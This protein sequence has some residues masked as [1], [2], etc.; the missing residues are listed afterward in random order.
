MKTGRFFFSC[1][2]NCKGWQSTYDSATDFR[3][4]QVPS[5]FPACTSLS[6]CCCLQG[7][8]RLPEFQPSHPSPREEEGLC[9]T[10]VISPF[11]WMF[12]RSP[13]QKLPLISY[14]PELSHM[15]NTKLNMLPEYIAISPK[16]QCFVLRKKERGVVVRQLEVFATLSV[17]INK[18]KQLL[19]LFPFCVGFLFFFYSK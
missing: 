12:P 17:Y 16:T 10:Y 14:W 15:E 9:P 5:V 6:C 7:P 11:K 8:K 18:C 1:D 13:I 2:E 3:R 19:P 4:I